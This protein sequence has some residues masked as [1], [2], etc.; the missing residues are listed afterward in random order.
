MSS[1]SEW[2]NEWYTCGR[3]DDG[4]KYD[5]VCI[6]PFLSAMDADKHTD[7]LANKFATAKTTLIPVC[8]FMPSFIKQKIVK[9]KVNNTLAKYERVSFYHEK[10]FDK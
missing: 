2:S 5:T 9:Y 1:L 8:K 6:G 7:K 10:F 4:V 3:F